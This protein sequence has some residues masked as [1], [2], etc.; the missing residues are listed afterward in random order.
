[1][2]PGHAESA[3]LTPFL[4]LGVFSCRCLS[5]QKPKYFFSV[6]FETK[7]EVLCR[8]WGTE[9]HQRI[10]WTA[11]VKSSHSLKGDDDDDDND[12]DDNGYDDEDDND[13]DDDDDDSW[14]TL[15]CTSPP[16][17]KSG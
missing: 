17:I 13:D 9:A 5:R 7:F 14:K 2:S 8:V 4:F 15:S 11:R 1:M 10:E 12:D 16:L 3:L 6:C